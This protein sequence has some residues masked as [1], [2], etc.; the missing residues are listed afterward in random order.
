MMRSENSNLLYTEKYR[1]KT[2]KDYVGFAHHDIL[3]YIERSLKGTEKKSA[4]ILTGLPG[5]GKTTLVSVIANHL[6]LNLI[7][8]NSSDKRKKRDINT[9][10]FRS[11]SITSQK[12]NVIVYDEADGI[13]KRGMKEL[14]KVIKKY[15]NPIIIIC[16]D[17]DKIPYSIRKLCYIKDFKVDHFSLKALANK[18]AEKENLNL[19]KGEIEKIVEK[20]STYRELLNNIQFGIT[21]GAVTNIDRDEMILQSLRGRYPRI[22]GNIQ[23]LITVYNDNSNEPNLISLADLYYE[24]YYNGYT[25][26]KKII[27]VILNSI[28]NRN[29]KKVEYPRTYRLIHEAKHGTRKKEQ[30]NSTNYNK[31]KIKIVGFK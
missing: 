15:S 24:R 5:S 29:I 3:N 8:S 30:T 20:S 6:N 10:S 12:K 11:T 25:Y 27:G 31:P 7:V 13:D 17:I 18:V 4:F 1:P 2:I 9:D 16:N 26:G 19:S 23:D 28:R 21:H 14:E 22:S